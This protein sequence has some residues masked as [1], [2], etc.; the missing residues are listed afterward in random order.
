MAVLHDER[1]LDINTDCSEFCPHP[2]HLHVLAVAAY[3]LDEATQ[4]RVGRLNLFAV[5]GSDGHTSFN[6]LQQA[7]KSVSLT[8]VALQRCKHAAGPGTGRWQASL[9]RRAGEHVQTIGIGAL[10]VCPH[11]I[12][13][14]IPLFG[15]Y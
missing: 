13:V 12:Y 1:I 11:I 14:P 6:N 2:E 5:G 15:C 10:L 8:P 3:Q 7:M 9:A 4:Q